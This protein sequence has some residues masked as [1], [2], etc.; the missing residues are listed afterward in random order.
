MG[1][2]RKEEEE[3]KEEGKEGGKEEEGEDQYSNNNN[4][5]TAI[6]TPLSTLNHDNEFNSP[7][8]TTTPNPN[9]PPNLPLPLPQIKTNPNKNDVLLGRG[10]YANSHSGNIFFRMLIR[11]NKKKYMVA[12]TS[13]AHKNS[14]AET[15]FKKNFDYG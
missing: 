7:S 1:N 11:E 2:Y 3:E 15:I 5:T 6:T 8:T 12:N 10:G 13:K 4:M 9:P 14:L